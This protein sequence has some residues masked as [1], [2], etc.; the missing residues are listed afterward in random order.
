MKPTI[1]CLREKND[2]EKK[3]TIYFNE[4]QE[5]TNHAEGRYVFLFFMN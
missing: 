4:C 3:Y 5:S 2:E 1:H